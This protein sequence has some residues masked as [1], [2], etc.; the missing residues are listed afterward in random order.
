M[1][2][3]VRPRFNRHPLTATSEGRRCVTFT[4]T[5]HRGLGWR[6]RGTVTLTGPHLAINH[7]AH[8]ATR[9]GPHR[10]T[11]TVTRGSR[12]SQTANEAYTVG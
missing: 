7:G 2:N 12:R 10:R 3:V 11:L 1:L 9:G 8:T 5:V 6:R 4:I